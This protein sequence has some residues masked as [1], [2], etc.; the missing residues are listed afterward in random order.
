MSPKCVLVACTLGLAGCTGSQSLAE[1]PLTAEDRALIETVTR[2]S[3][4]SSRVGEGMNWRNAESGH[5]GNVTPLL[6][7]TNE[8]GKSCR[9]FQQTIAIDGQTTIAYDSAC[10]QAD[11]NWASLNHASLSDAIA[12][13]E[14][15]GTGAYARP[16][17]QSYQPRPYYYRPFPYYYG[18]HYGF[19]YRYKPSRYQPYRYRPYRYYDRPHYG[20]RSGYGRHFG[21]QHRYR[22][23]YH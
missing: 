1:S 22:R 6:D 18:P 9:D 2:E 8:T 21:Q 14:S 4:E 11:E 5:G 19:Q 7:Y 17:P 13:A 20:F 15:N 3:L 16:S 12:S 23:S 10:R